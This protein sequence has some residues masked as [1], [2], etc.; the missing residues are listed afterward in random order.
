MA[1]KGKL[2]NFLCMEYW[3]VDSLVQA[4]EIYCCFIKDMYQYNKLIKG[5]FELGGCEVKLK[6]I[7]MLVLIIYVKYDYIVLLVMIKLI[8]DEIG[9]KDKE[10][11]EFLGG[12]IGVFVGGCF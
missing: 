10:L 3:V 12:Y 6:N 5:E 8:N 2:M 11:M 7:N 4:G 1:N 9:L